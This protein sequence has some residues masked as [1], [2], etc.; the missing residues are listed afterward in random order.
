MAKVIDE[1]PLTISVEHDEQRLSLAIAGRADH[2][3]IS[4]VVDVLG[5]LADEHDRCVSLDLAGLESM[6]THALK[7]L[8]GSADMFRQRRKRLHLK[9]ASE[10][11]Q[12]FLD[13]LLMSDLFCAQK[14]CKAG[15]D[16][17]TCNLADDGWATDVFTLPL[18]LRY[19]REARARVDQVA[20]AIGFNMDRRGDVKLAVG[21]AVTNAVKYGLT[22]DDPD[23]FTVSCFGTPEK[24]CISVTDNGPGFD[25]DDLP[26]LEEAK[27]LEH[28]RGIHCI[29]AVMDEVSFD[30]DCGTTVRMVKFRG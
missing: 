10:A 16:S 20:E 17:S 24:L 27:V 30:F 1:A 21:E 5:R 7:G 9:S 11:V 26:T 4:D 12:D 2:S 14:E 25:M 19:C 8:V 15:C 13:R 6:D 3:N 18:D 29:N 23:W 22:A 28:G